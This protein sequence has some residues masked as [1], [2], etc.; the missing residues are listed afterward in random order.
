MNTGQLAE[1]IAAGF[2]ALGV[3]A[4]VYVMA[5]R[6]ADAAAT[7]AVADYRDAPTC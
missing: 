7:D 4:A 2:F 6:P 5:G 3:C 1:L